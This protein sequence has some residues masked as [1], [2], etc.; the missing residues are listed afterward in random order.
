VTFL[1]TRV[2]NM[3]LVFFVITMNSTAGGL[4]LAQYTL[5]PI[6]LMQWYWFSKIA[7]TLVKRLR[8]GAKGGEKGEK[9]K[10]KKLH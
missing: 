3:P 8:G 9:K 2:I 6:S 5:L 4:G 7:S 1:L 10:D